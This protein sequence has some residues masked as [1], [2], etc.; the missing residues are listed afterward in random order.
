MWRDDS[1]GAGRASEMAREQ[2]CEAALR[3]RSRTHR[4]WHWAAMSWSRS[5]KR[6]SVRGGSRRELGSRGQ[7]KARGSFRARE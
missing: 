1:V 6:A 4:S 2:S 5:S 7:G 3:D